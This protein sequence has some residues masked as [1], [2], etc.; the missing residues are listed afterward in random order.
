[1]K[2]HTDTRPAVFR[3]FSLAS[4]DESAAFIGQLARIGA[5]H[6]ELIKAQV[7]P[8]GVRVCIAP[9][10]AEGKKVADRLMGELIELYHQSF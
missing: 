5:D 1:M 2:R 6:A 7:G 3:T 4:L 8:G 10:P 9:H